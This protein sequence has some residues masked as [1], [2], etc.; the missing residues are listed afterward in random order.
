MKK[1]SIALYI[2]LLISVVASGM[3]WAS[4]DPSS[5]VTVTADSSSATTSQDT[6]SAD[7]SSDTTTSTDTSADTSGTESDAS[8]G[9]GES[10]AA[11]EDTSSASETS[12]AEESSSEA[13]SAAS[14]SSS[15][16]QASSS[17]TVSKTPPPFQDEGYIYGTEDEES[18][19]EVTSDSLSQPADMDGDG[20][21]D[22]EEEKMDNSVAGRIT[23]IIWIPILLAVAS[24]AGLV[25]INVLYR[26]KYGKLSSGNKKEK[27]N[28]KKDKKTNIYIPRD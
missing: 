25:T 19:V 10:S 7:A 28:K 21:D 5:D 22:E 17:S 8:S 16:A 6:G 14:S 24:A 9:E 15:Q 27:K 2:V 23:R 1:L 3:L 13:S 20:I 12:S 18:Y 11:S 4:A 26:K